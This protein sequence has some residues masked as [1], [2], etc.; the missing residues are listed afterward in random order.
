MAPSECTQRRIVSR[1]DNSEEIRLIIVEHED[2]EAALASRNSQREALLPLSK[3]ATEQD[4]KALALTLTGGRPNDLRY[5][6]IIVVASKDSGMRGWVVGFLRSD[7][8]NVV[9]EGRVFVADT[10]FI[11]G[12]E[13]EVSLEGGTNR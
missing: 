10:P 4:R 9:L 2:M 5:H 12:S 11:E 7:F 13:V 8:R 1:M 3:L 6:R